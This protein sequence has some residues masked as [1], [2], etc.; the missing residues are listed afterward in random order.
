MIKYS[1]EQEEKMYDLYSAADTPEGRE[2]VVMQLATEWGKPKRSIIAKLSKMKIYISKAKI[3]KV[4]GR[5]PETKEQLVVKIEVRFGVEEGKFMGLE[6][7]PKLVLKALLE[8]QIV[9]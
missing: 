7:A 8:N 3:S 9:K 1:P 6:K 2:Q 5:H 4:T